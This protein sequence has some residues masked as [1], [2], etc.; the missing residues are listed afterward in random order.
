[1]GCAKA[2]GGVLSV[3]L[4][5]GPSAGLRAQTLG[6][7]EA[8]ARRTAIRVEIRPFGLRRWAARLPPALWRRA[9]RIRPDWPR[10]THPG[11]RAALAPLPDGPVVVIGAGRPSAPLTAA[12]RAQRADAFAVQILDP[13]IDLELFDL[14][15]T[16]AHDGL[17]GERV[18]E[19][20]GSIGRVT[21]ALARRAADRQAARFAHLPKPRVAILVG[22]RSRDFLWRPEDEARLVSSCL[23]IAAAGFGVVATPSARTP[24]RLVEALVRA[25]PESSAWVWGGQGENPYPAML[26]LASAALVTEDSVNMASEAAST[27]VPVHLFPLA[28]RAPRMAAFQDAL[29]ARGAARRYAGRIERWTYAPLAEADRVADHLLR[30]L[31]SPAPRPGRGGAAPFS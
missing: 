2:R 7:S 14:V 1:M 22:G 23:E 16:P 13:E 30:R 28:S 12:L 4:L 5:D 6:L 19:T 31:R 15:A 26:G 11:A 10:L 21:A 24:R 8:L 29:I 3:V 27:G 25:L 17:R 18:V 9:A 20:L